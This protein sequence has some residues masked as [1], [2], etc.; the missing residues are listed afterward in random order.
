MYL[1]DWHLSLF[2]K[3][4]PLE[5][6]TKVWDAYLCEGEVYVL[7]VGLGIL[8]MFAPKLST[9]SVEKI[10]PF[11][12]HLPET[13]KA[14][15][16]FA[17]VAQISISKRH[18]EKI[19]KRTEQAHGNTTTNTSDHP[20]HTNHNSSNN[21]S[22]SNRNHAL[23]SNV[24]AT[25]GHSQPSEKG[26]QASGNRTFTASIKSVVRS[27]LRAFRASSSTTNLAQRNSADAFNYSN[28][29][30]SD[31]GGR[32]RAHTTTSTA[33][34]P[35]DRLVAA[36][37]SPTSTPSYLS[38]LPNSQWRGTVKSKTIASIQFTEEQRRHLQLQQQKANQ[39]AQFS[40][41]V[42]GGSSQQQQLPPRQKAQSISSIGTN[43]S[44]GSVSNPQNNKP[45]RKNA[46][47]ATAA[48]HPDPGCV[49]S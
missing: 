10:C 29:S 8:K 49:P 42:G 5:I 43:N 27:S 35:Q 18:Y 46:K 23:H 2:T 48:Y 28:G 37:F 16:L 38:S 9:F 15:E 47:D 40:Q 14:D 12:L 36:A 25:A 34:T 13:I 31:G 3:A 39:D 41:D 32:Q 17:N 45:N 30:S 7:S 33:S 4:L 21:N 26:V 19:R 24:A 20:Q 44:G 1:M 11:L 6:A 22:H